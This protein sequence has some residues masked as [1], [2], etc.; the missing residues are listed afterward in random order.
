MVILFGSKL[1]VGFLLVRFADLIYRNALP[2]MSG[3]STL[4]IMFLIE[5]ALFVVPTIILFHPRWK[6]RAKLLFISAVSLLLAGAVLRFNALIVGF[7]PS[8]GYVYFP[9]VIELLVSIGLLAVEIAGFMLIVKR[10]PILPPRIK[11]MQSGSA[12]SSAR[13]ATG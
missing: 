1:L 5:T 8:A 10:Y 7:I 2:A 4:T 13:V 3:N 12:A 9:T 11:T 6:G